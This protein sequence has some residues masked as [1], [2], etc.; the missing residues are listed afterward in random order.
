[1]KAIHVG[2]HDTVATAITDLKPGDEAL[3]VV[4]KEPIP[5]GHKFATA[6]IKKGDP[7]I[8][9]DSHIGTANTD[10]EPGMWVHV[11]NLDGERG[12][13]D[14]EDHPERRGHGARRRESRLRAAWRPCHDAAG[15]QS[16][17]SRSQRNQ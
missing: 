4:I 8:K 6:F 5:T 17:R 9:Y 2:A 3:G 1:M 15:C 13:G 12:R 7:V 14:R 10:I 11:H 16:P